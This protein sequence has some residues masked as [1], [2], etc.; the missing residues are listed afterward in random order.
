MEVSAD[1]V[2][3]EYL[4]A[5]HLVAGFSPPLGADNK[6]V[7]SLQI[8]NR[9]PSLHC[10]LLTRREVYSKVGNVAGFDA[11][12]LHPVVVLQVGQFP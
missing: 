6:E 2:H 4:E 9:H 11:D 3:Q 7:S 1:D 8:A 10:V 12:K 5:E